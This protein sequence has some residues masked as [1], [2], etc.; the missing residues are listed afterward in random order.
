ML[1]MRRMEIAR[2][3]NVPCDLHLEHLNCRLRR[4]IKGLRS[5]VTPKALCHAA[6]SVGIV[7]EVCS[8]TV[9]AASQESFKELITSI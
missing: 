8:N 3:C 9:E 2:G 4:I 6:Q 7:H 1:M 5:N